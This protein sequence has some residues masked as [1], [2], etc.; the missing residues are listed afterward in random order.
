MRYPHVAAR[1]FDTPLLVS[2]APLKAF[3]A[4][5]GPR[6]G[7]EVSGVQVSPRKKAYDD[8][9]GGSGGYR[10]YTVENGVARLPIL[11]P[12]IHRVLTM[13]DICEGYTGYTDL[14]ASFRAAL[15]DSRARAIVL[16]IDSPGGEVS[17]VFDLADEIY[18]ARGVKPIVAV[19]ADQACS[20]AYLLASA[21]DEV[22]T[23]QTGWTGS[24]GV[25]WTHVD[26]S[27]ANEQLGIAVTHIFAGDHKVDGTPFA[28][29]PDDVR[30]EIQTS[31]D[32]TYRLFVDKVARN[33]AMSAEDVIAT[34]ARVYE[35]GDGAD[36]RLVDRVGT[37][38]D[39]MNE[40]AEKSRPTASIAG[41]RSGALAAQR[42]ENHMTTQV[43][44]PAGEGSADINTLQQR[45]AAELVRVRD[46]AA[47]GQR[48]AV[49]A[50]RSD[51]RARVAAII[52]SE[53]AKGREPLAQHFAFQ[54]EMPAEAAVAALKAAPKAEAAAPPNRFEA[55]MA[56]V[57]N[58][59]V[60]A[61]DTAGG[62]D[63]NAAIALMSNVLAARR[64]VK[65]SA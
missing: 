28:P 5:L 10:G 23:T 41:T 22:V 25:V 33:R 48:V 16:E 62:D 14:T 13:D 31:V 55:A 53:D 42:S 15:S 4:A 12:L 60:G 61:D 63:A 35:G 2:P 6:M 44:A 24:V 51:E 50:A 17:G 7:F 52:G 47:E 59:Q 38:K 65:R 21:A 27:Q 36:V 64:G 9:D 18:A 37:L 43:D 57:R 32:K 56:G 3:L 49:I 20:A 30:A 54:T 40:L 34:Q 11:G 46:E 29:L 58:P 39:T 8:D 26:I 19:A 1:L 45:H